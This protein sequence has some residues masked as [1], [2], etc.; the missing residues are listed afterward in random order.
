MEPQPSLKK[1]YFFNISVQIV[2]VLYPLITIPYITRILGPEALGKVNF[3]TSFVQYFI[4]F[5]N[6]GIGAYASREI[7]K[8][9]N[10]IEKLNQTFSELFSILFLS[11]I[12]FSITYLSTLILIDK[13][14]TD[15]TLYLIV[16]IPLFLNQMSVSWFFLGTENF[17]YFAIRNVI[18]KII[19]IALIFILIKTPEDYLLYAFILSLSL[20]G[21]NI[22]DFTLALKYTKPHLTLKITKHFKPLLIFFLSSIFSVLYSGIDVIVL[23]FLEQTNSDKFVGLFTTAKKIILFIL[24][25]LNS[26]INVNYIRLS[27]L[28]SQNRK[29]EYQE[30]MKKTTN[31]LMSISFLIFTITFSL[32]EEILGIL[33]GVKFIEANITLKVLSILLITNT[34]RNIIESQLLNPNNLER[35]VLIGN[36]TGWSICFISLFPLTLLFSYHGTSVSILIGDILNLIFFLIVSA[37]HLK[38]NPLSRN[39][40]TYGLTSVVILIVNELIHIKFHIKADNIL[41]LLLHTSLL[42]GIY[43]TIY[44]FALIIA[45][46]YTIKEILN[47]LR[48]FLNNRFSRNR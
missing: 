34:L 1:N 3:A 37:K 13:I 14:K 45:K 22:L 5:A 35:F 46:D 42:G 25:L 32:S 40:I 18:L 6:L 39:I 16:G 30:L 44:L 23:G 47:T 27:F 8:I 36:I 48:K 29:E 41:N 19:T 17:K 43:T 31:F 7:S 9:R 26:I 38:I 24:F 28:I 21:A 10:N 12:F 4:T 2:N 33:G 20:F 15:I 11:S